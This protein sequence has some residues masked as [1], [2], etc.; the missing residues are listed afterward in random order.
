MDYAEFELEYKRVTELIMTGR[1]NQIQPA[2]IARLR[3][4]AT[5]IDDEDDREIADLEVSGT[6]WVLAQDPGKPPSEILMQAR[7]LYQEASRDDGTDAERLARAEHGIEALMRIESPT[8][9]DAG[10]IGSLEHVLR[11]LADALRS[12]LHRAAGVDSVDRT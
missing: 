8:P 11:M 6:E 12:Q 10:A 1:T 5:Q 3:T 4:L 2:D 9:E 7:G